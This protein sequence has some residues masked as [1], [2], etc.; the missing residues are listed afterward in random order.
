MLTGRKLLLADDSV[1]IQKVVTLTFGDEGMQVTT[2]SDGKEALDRFRELQPDVVLA[3]IHMPELNGYELCAQIKQDERFK[4][5]PVMLL[6]GSFEPFDEEEARRVG[7][8]DYLTKPFQSIKQLVTKVG[9]LLGGS[10]AE[11]V[12]EGATER[13]ADT[14]E[15]PALASTEEQ[16]AGHSTEITTM[17]AEAI[18]VTTANTIPLHPLLESEAAT[19]EEEE[20]PEPLYAFDEE[21]AASSS[22]YERTA[23]QRAEEP[24]YAQA[25]S[26]S[27]FGFAARNDDML[28]DLGDIEP[29]YSSTQE[30]DFILDLQDEAFYRK[31]T[32]V[33]APPVEEMAT[34]AA[35]ESVSEET[36][37]APVQLEEEMFVAEAAPQAEQFAEAQLAGEEQRAELAS[38]GMPVE[39]EQPQPAPQA[40]S[41]A[42]A[43]QIGLDQLSPEVI[44][45][46]A[47]RAVEHLSERV[48]QQIAWEVVPQLAE[49]LIK[50]RLE[51][52]KT[53]TR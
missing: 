43:G 51:E 14:Q 29:D 4:D 2:V 45:T 44:E 28:L 37:D 31:P 24:A 17:D 12:T 19:D 27:P 50:R 13:E 23:R 5:V 36:L 47:R 52:E 33:A 41:Q 48:V 6:V 53:Q 49:L 16:H 8:D 10:Q 30:D 7:A 35:A 32:L 26:G 18:E 40:Q 39:E 34:P 3:D 9:S 25:A 21:Q 15:L 11:S 20:Q 1:T 38:A 42:Q 46:I 22:E